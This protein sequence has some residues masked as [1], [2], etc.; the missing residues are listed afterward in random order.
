M[1]I[2]KIERVNLN[3]FSY[4]SHRLLFSTYLLSVISNAVG[5]MFVPLMSVEFATLF[6]FTLLV[7][8]SAVSL[9]Y[10]LINFVITLSNSLKKSLS[11][12]LTHSLVV[13]TLTM[14]NYYKEIENA[15]TKSN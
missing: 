5:L 13:D 2:L 3:D 9:V 14:D 15:R 1:M 7:I 11:E 10:L 4:L 12:F 8:V 6:S